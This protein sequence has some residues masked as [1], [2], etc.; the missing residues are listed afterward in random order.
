[1]GCFVVEW[2]GVFCC[3]VEWGVLSW[4]G[5]GWGVWY[6]ND[7]VTLKSCLK[8]STDFSRLDHRAVTELISCS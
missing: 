6:W 5:V 8:N 3:G 7:C 4:R 1:M 2:S